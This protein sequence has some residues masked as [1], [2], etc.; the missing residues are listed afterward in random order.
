MPA[1]KLTIPSDHFKL[2]ATG[3]AEA[4]LPRCVAVA[5]L[6]E[7]RPSSLDGVIGQLVQLPFVAVGILDPIPALHPK[8]EACSP[9]PAIAHE[10]QEATALAS[11][12]R[13][14]PA[15]SLE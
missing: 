12:A 2:Q 6:A 9:H 1:Q 10:V 15:A 13:P 4:E 14:V 5:R 3:F 11:I 8:R 7:L